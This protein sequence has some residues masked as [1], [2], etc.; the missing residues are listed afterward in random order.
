MDDSITQYKTIQVEKNY[1]K[2][3][4]SVSWMLI[5]DTIPI[6]IMHKNE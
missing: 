2:I 3:I 5:D 1:I 6:M 4:L